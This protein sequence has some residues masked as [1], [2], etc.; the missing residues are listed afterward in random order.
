MA[1]RVNCA[2]FAEVEN[3][4]VNKFH[5]YASHRGENHY[6]DMS[7]KPL[8]IWA[9]CAGNASLEEFQWVAP[10]RRSGARKT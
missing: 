9:I 3:I 6:F 4:T 5:H 10:N 8:L 2:Y 7:S 1:P